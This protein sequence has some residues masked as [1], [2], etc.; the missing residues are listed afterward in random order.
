MDTL[1]R[2]MDTFRQLMRPRIAGCMDAT[3][4]NYN[5]NAIDD[6]GSCIPPP[7]LTSW[8]SIVAAVFTICLLAWCLP[9]AALL[10]LVEKLLAT[11]RA[12][13]VKTAVA[14]SHVAVHAAAAL[15]WLRA[16]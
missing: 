11:R 5:P 1:M 12:F 7:F 8:T 3:M 6:D 2:P 16:S 10:H 15:A 9:D 13:Q 4:S 14:R